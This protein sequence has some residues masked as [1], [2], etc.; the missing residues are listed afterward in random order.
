MLIA[1][2][3]EVGYSTVKTI[4]REIR[5]AAAEVFVPLEYQPGDL[6]Q[7]DFFEVLVDIGG[8]KSKAWMFLLRVM[9]SGRDFAR[10]YDRQD[11]V[12]VACRMFRKI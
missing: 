1:E 10:I 7:A 11:Q 12:R 9:H 5:R 4:E 2:K 8:V 3:R 6:A